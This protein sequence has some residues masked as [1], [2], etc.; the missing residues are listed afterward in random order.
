MTFLIVTVNSALTLIAIVLSKFGPSKS[1]KSLRPI[2]G[3]TI[4]TIV[5]IT[6]VLVVSAILIGQKELNIAKGDQSGCRISVVQPNIAQEMK[7][8]PEQAR[9]ILN[10]LGR[11][12]LEAAGEKPDLIVWPETSTPG[13]LNQNPMVRHEVASII[14]SVETPLLLGSSARSKFRTS[15]AERR[16]Y[17][18]LA[19]LIKNTNDLRRPQSYAKVRLLPFGEYLPYEEH[20]S[21]RSLGA[22]G[23]NGYV[24]GKEIKVFSLNDF[25]FAVTICWENIFPDLVRE[26]VKNG[27]Q[28]IVNITNEAW[29]GKTAAPYQFLA[30][31]VFRAVENRVYV[32]RCA[33]TGIS[34]IID[35]WG[36]LVDRVKDENG[37]D[38]FVR[39]ILTGIVIPMDAHTFYTRFGDVF[40]WLCFAV[41]AGFL[42]AAV[43]VKKRQRP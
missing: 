32:V 38:V 29:F 15:G 33:N 7:W 43:F 22:P 24:A 4:F 42:V 2:P 9:S 18:N 1:L 23:I 35:P 14:R 26:F 25:K 12:T 34:C 20:V 30:M 40:A 41:S 36:R 10:T 5:A 13:A 6:C 19:Y 39:G 3:G 21:W 8:E 16:K 11:M 28:F 27:A 17:M 31:S 37:R